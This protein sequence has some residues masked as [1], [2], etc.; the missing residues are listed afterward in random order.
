MEEF[1]KMSTQ[2]Q[3]LLDEI[4]NHQNLVIINLKSIIDKKTKEIVKEA[5]EDATNP[6]PM[7][8]KHD[9]TV[10]EYINNPNSIDVNDLP[11]QTAVGSNG[12]MYEA[13]VNPLVEKFKQT[14]GELADQ[15]KKTF[16]DKGPTVILPT[17][18]DDFK[19]KTV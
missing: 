9:I 6:T 2:V 4:Y 13:G 14:F 8:F 15:N 11:R 10:R 19:K 17:V 18:E 16:S 7:V 3:E 5:E 12:Q 1:E